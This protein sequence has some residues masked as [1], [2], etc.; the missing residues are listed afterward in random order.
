MMQE[1]T[2]RNLVPII[3]RKMTQFY[4]TIYIAH[5]HWNETLKSMQTLQRSIIIS[6]YKHI[7][8]AING[9]R[10]KTSNKKA[11]KREYVDER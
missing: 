11:M 1:Y 5:N 10:R 7:L 8:K 9:L 2:R 6:K 3:R 4:P